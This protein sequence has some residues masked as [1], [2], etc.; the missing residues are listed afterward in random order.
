MQQP[1]RKIVGRRR[2]PLETLAHLEDLTHFLKEHVE[3]ALT[4][5]E[6]DFFP[7]RKTVGRSR[8]REG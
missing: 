1:I 7:V 6:G 4:R 3:G 2:T 8:K 5:V